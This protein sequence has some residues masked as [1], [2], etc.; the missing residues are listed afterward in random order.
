MVLKCCVPNRKSN[1]ASSNNKIP[2]YKLPQNNEDKKKWIAAIPRANLVASKYPA[3]CRKHWP[4]NATFV[5]V[6]GKQRPK[7][8]PSIFPDN[9]ASYLRSAQKTF[10]KQQNEVCLVRASTLKMK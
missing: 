4:E 5:L 1:Y 6:Y 10:S 7:D 8:P 3:L 2:V 9:P